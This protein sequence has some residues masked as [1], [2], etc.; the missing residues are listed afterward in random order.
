MSAKKIIL[1][2]G[3][4]HKAKDGG[5][6]FYESLVKGFPEP[7]KVLVC[8]FARPRGNWE[9]AF[10]QDKNYFATNLPNVNIEIKL[11]TQENFLEELGW[12]NAIYFRGGDIN[13]VPFMSQYP[14]WQNYLEEKVVAGS[15]MGAY[16]LSKYYFD[17]TSN[18]IKNGTGITNT[19][20][21]V[22]WKSQL[23]EYVNTKWEDG[24][25]ELVD[26]KENLPT[27]KLAEGEFVE[28]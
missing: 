3:Y 8:L 22:H 4:P 14:N 23:P 28:V 15:S 6:A 9:D 20:V 21:I 16:M 17:I 12:C 1:V 13:L 24:Y 27:Y 26:Y 7:V 5:K 18:T 19:K 2:G 25:K 11:A 10:L